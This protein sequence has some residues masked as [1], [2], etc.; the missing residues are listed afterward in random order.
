M[1]TNEKTTQMF[2]VIMKKGTI[3]KITFG[4][5]IVYQRITVR[6]YKY[7]AKVTFQGRTI[8][9]KGKDLIKYFNECKELS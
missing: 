1:K 9:L 2:N 7:K 8:T 6:L 4:Y 5:K 3:T